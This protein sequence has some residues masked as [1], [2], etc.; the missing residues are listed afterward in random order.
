MT[1]PIDADDSMESSGWEQ[2]PVS[3]A[4]L[5]SDTFVF[6]W[7][8]RTN[9]DALF[10]VYW[11]NGTLMTGPIQADGDIT[12]YS[13]KNTIS[14][15][16]LTSTTFVMS[17]FDD[18]DDDDT[19]SVYWTNGTLKHGPI[20]S[21]TNTE[22]GIYWQAV[23]SSELVNNI[24]FCNQNFV[25]SFVINSTSASW[26]PY[27]SNGTIWNGT[28]IS[29]DSP[30]QIYSVTQPS[31]VT[32][33][34]G[35]SPTFLTVNFS[36]YD[37][38][39]ASNLNSSTASIN[40]TKSGEASRQNNSCVMYE[41]SGNYANY[42]C[43][44]TMWWFDAA[45]ND[46]KI[47][48]NISDLDSNIAVNDTIDFTVNSLTGFV[49]DYSS[50]NFATLVAGSHNQTPVNHFTLNNTGNVD[51]TLGNIEVNA[52][53]L[54]GEK[55][56]NQFLF[57]GNFSAS[58]YTGDKIECNITG[59]ATQMN[60][61]TFTKVS[62]TLLTAGNYTLNNGIGQEELYFCL[63][64]VGIELTQ[65]QY[66][67]DVF[68]S[69]TI[70]IVLVALSIRRKK[71]K[72][73]KESENITIPVIIFSKNLGALEALSKYMKENLG[74]SYHNIGELLNRNEKTIWTAYNKAIGKQ[75]EIIEV[76]GTEI[77][78]PISKLNNRELTILESV[79]IYLRKKDLKYSEIGKLINR[80]QRN[81]RSIY[82]ETENRV[83]EEE[84]VEFNPTIPLTI[85]SSELGA[86]EATS[87]YMKE[88][89]GLSY[90]NIGKLLNRDERTIWTAY[91]KAIGKQKEIIEVNEKD[92][93]LP[94]SIFNNRELTILESVIIYLRKKEMKYSEI[95]KLINRDQRNVR[96]IYKKIENNI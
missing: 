18:V 91:N 53:D 8:D 45:G 9:N 38:N 60:N 96:G 77:F 24:G 17:W 78:I 58:P 68:G 29:S 35:P 86:L 6:S 31:P 59:S 5:T 72:N 43:N 4:A 26:I 23:S 7:A 11:T 82:Y 85:F 80:D 32:L 46:W 54:V 20:D 89:L 62:N 30:P 87:K 14:L 56:Y 15:S 28:C 1:G 83:K 22:T 75:K 42:T 12:S 10:S 71:K 50:L 47:Y 88:N 61:Y 48:A 70:R 49:V 52:T 33:T 3:I 44:V 67:T 21:E 40:F 73:S 51:I 76:K 64:E 13:N 84:F 74:L 65:Q 2:Q 63:R 36:V 94:L 41:S 66:S 79:I 37:A 39:G 69:W 81:V 16:R 92:L 93:S 57:A 95:G 27:L 34:D 90:H 19:F 55:T 25:H